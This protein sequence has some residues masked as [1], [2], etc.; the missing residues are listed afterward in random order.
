MWEAFKNFIFWA[1]DAFYGLVGDWGMAII[2]I[3]VI[4]RAAIT[5]LMYTQSKS[6]YR[7]Q[8]MQPVIQQIKER[9]PDDVARQNAETQKLYADA[10]FNPLAGCVPMLIQMPIFIALFQVLREMPERVHTESYVFLNLIPDLTTS[11]SV[12]F[13]G[14]FSAFL[15]YLILLAIFALGTFV[16]TILMQRNQQNAQ[17]KQQMIIM[18]VVMSIMMIWVGWGSPAGVLLFWGASSLLAIAQQQISM[19]LIKKNDKEEIASVYEV[20]VDMTVERKVKKKRPNKK[21][22]H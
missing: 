5:P 20:P 6:S 3:T 21:K 8:K 11:P 16:P 4:F 13:A 10:K 14:G 19:R 12:A 9:F 18:V 2:I 1:I 17:Q 15:P 7:M 22:K